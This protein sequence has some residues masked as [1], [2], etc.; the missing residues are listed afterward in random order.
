[1]GSVGCVGDQTVYNERK[2]LSMLY[3]STG[4]NNWIDADNWKEDSVSIC[5]WHGVHCVKE[6]SDADHMKFIAF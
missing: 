4:G 6:T 1:M 3:D 5:D 2:I